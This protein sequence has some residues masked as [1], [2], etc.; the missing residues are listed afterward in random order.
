[1]RLSKGHSS[2]WRPGWSCGS[3]YIY[4][5]VWHQ[6]SWVL[7]RLTCQ[8]NFFSHSFLVLFVFC[9]LLASACLSLCRSLVKTMCHWVGAPTYRMINL[10]LKMQSSMM[11]GSGI[12]YIACTSIESPLDTAWLQL[13]WCLLSLAQN[14]CIHS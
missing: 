8:Y 5:P 4:I 14:Q 7:H 11:S 1:M 9:S 13:M 3:I 2:Y 10:H 6:S 12:C